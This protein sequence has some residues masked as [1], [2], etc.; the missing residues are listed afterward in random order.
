MARRLKDTLPKSFTRLVEN[1]DVDALKE[2][3]TD[4]AL[5]ARDREG[6]MAL[7][8]IG[9]PEEVKIWLVEQGAD[10]NVANAA[11]DTPLHAH[12]A[13]QHVAPDFLLERGADVDAEN[14]AG[15][16]PTF[17]AVFSLGNLR[18]LIQAGADPYTH[19]D[20]GDTPLMRVIRNSEPGQI[21]QL[22]D[23]VRLLDRNPFTQS[24]LEEARD[25]IIDLG[26][27]FQGIRE[28]Y[29]PDTVDRAAQ[30]MIF[31]YEAFSITE[32]ERPV[33]PVRHDGHSRIALVGESWEE[34]FV[35]SWDYLVPATGKAGSLQGEAI[36]IAGRIADEFH[37]NDG[38]DW[39][40]DF[41]RMAGALI[42]IT[43]HGT[44]LREQDAAELKIAVKKVR[45]G[46][47]S[48]E[49]VDALP[50]LVTAWLELNPEPLGMVEVDYHR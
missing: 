31:L 46:H 3:F 38:A 11:G 20:A 16:N 39:D 32:D 25:C 12:V 45:R 8:L 1:R 2:V 50:R 22:A 36:R 49:E 21:P 33:Q 7:H 37:G 23:L 9:V 43:S 26:E 29:D 4:R 18:K 10:I 5:D 13:K 47:P 35:Y 41:R 28:V 44:P 42:T 24:E 27:R 19:N 15:E 48:G 6:N 40:D 30:D 14:N 34:R 17:A